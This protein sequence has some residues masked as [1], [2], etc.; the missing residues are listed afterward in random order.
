MVIPRFFWKKYIMQVKIFYKLHTFQE[1]GYIRVQVWH[2]KYR[3][4]YKEQ[5]QR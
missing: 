1:Q 4:K 3:S 5:S 2:K